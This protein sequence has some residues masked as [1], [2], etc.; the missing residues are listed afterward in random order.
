[1]LPR[2]VTRP[3]VESCGHPTGWSTAYVDES[4]RRSQYRLCAVLCC[5]CSAPETRKTLRGMPL[6]GQPRLHAID[7]TPS[8]RRTVT[9]Q[10]VELPVSACITMARGKNTAARDET[11]HEMLDALL[12]IRV[13]SL[14]LELDAGSQARDRS[15]IANHLR[16]RR[17]TLPY[18]HVSPNEEPLVW[19][20]DYVAWMHGKDARHRS[21]IQKILRG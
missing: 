11:L 21:L 6:P 19:V 9:A 17:E 1:M 16:G 12:A 15:T 4:V 20:A 7:D 8:R 2:R 5:S 13:G 14:V 18:R 10:L 3:P